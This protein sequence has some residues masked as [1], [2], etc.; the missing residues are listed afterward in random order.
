MGGLCAGR[1]Q[2]AGLYSTAATKRTE[3]LPEPPLEVSTATGDGPWRE[4]S[5]KTEVYNGSRSLL[6]PPRLLPLYLHMRASGRNIGG[7]GWPQGSLTG[8]DASW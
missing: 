3:F 8:K 6:V 4:G 2:S 7:P 1:F 5:E